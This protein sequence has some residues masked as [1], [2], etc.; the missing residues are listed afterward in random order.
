MVMTKRRCGLLLGKLIHLARLISRKAVYSTISYRCAKRAPVKYYYQ[1]RKEFGAYNTQINRL[2]KYGTTEMYKSQFGMTRSEYHSLFMKVRPLLEPKKF[3]R[4]ST[5]I[6]ARE[7][8]I[9]TLSY[10]KSGCA[11][12][13]LA[14]QFVLSRCRVCRI[15]KKVTTAISVCLAEHADFRP[16]STECWEKIAQ[17]FHERWQL[18]HCIGAVDGKH[19]FITKFGKTGSYTINYHG[20]PSVILLA[21]CDADY[22]IRHFNVG[23]FG[24]R[25]DG[26]IWSE[27]RL[28]RGL[29]SGEFLERGFIPA[30]EIL[31]NDDQERL[32]RVNYYIVGDDAFPLHAHCMK[33]Y[34]GKVS[35]SQRMTNYRLSRGRMV[36]ECV[37]GHLSR[38]W[39]ILSHLTTNEEVTRLILKSCVHL[40][41]FLRISRL[42]DAD[43]LEL[44]ENPPSELFG[45]SLSLDDSPNHL[46]D[47]GERTRTRLHYYFNYVNPI[48]IQR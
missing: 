29:A 23:S 37:F 28:G 15:I 16:R 14:N 35:K 25:S 4:K 22:I 21:V 40:H 38:K 3:N 39:K 18:P 2:L 30:A 44:I 8:L 20:W 5:S 43:E 45:R 47:S 31:P 24:G 26:G 19:C 42:D 9:L 11:Q 32:G 33:P 1:G 13:Y 10:L 36:I 7:Q 27:D 17:R 46:V 12:G 6:S 41:N 48:E 34:R